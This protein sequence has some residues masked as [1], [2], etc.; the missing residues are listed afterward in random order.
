MAEA[1]RQKISDFFKRR[2]IEKRA[3]KQTKKLDRSIKL[4]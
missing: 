3:L 4:F 1:C 2:R